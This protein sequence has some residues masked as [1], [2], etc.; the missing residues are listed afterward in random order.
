MFRRTKIAAL[1]S[2][3]NN[4]ELRKPFLEKARV[5]SAMYDGCWSSVCVTLW[6]NCTDWHMTALRD[7]LCFFRP[8]LPPKCGKYLRNIPV[9]MLWRVLYLCNYH[10]FKSL[11][12]RSTPSCV[13]SNSSCNS[14]WICGEPQASS[15]ACSTTAVPGSAVQS[16]LWENESERSQHKSVLFFWMLEV[17]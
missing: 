17:G 2:C 8:I 4:N 10:S 9:L 15:T 11:L 6:T 7:V 13:Y 16:V 1:W 12:D 14:G 3:C 5:W